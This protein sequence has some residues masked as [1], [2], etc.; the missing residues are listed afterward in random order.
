MEISYEDDSGFSADL[1]MDVVAFESS[2]SYGEKSGITV[3]AVVGGLYFDHRKN[4]MQ[5]KSIDGIIGLA[6]RSVSSAN[7]LTPLDYL[8]RD[9]KYEIDD[10][11]SLCLDSKVGGMMIIGSPD[12]DPQYQSYDDV[13][14][15]PL[16]KETYYPVEMKGML[17][18]RTKVD[19]DESVFNNG[20]AIVDR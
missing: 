6:Y 15:T 4:P 1:W 7:T 14:W 20:D 9:D 12:S 8:V 10:V 19:V 3:Q 18:G 11:F 2:E 13:Q 16:T 5:P 17:V